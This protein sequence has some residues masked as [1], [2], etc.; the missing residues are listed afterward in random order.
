[1][2]QFVWFKSGHI[3]VYST[4]TASLWLAWWKNGWQGTRLELVTWYTLIIACSIDEFHQRFTP[5]RTSRLLDI[6]IDLL[7]A[8]AVLQVLKRYNRPTPLGSGM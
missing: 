4:L 1:M 5:G 2:H 3:V 7:A 6:F 8:W